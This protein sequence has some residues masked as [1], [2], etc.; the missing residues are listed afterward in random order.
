MTGG[1]GG[2]SHGFRR[3]AQTGITTR[4]LFQWRAASENDTTI[5]KLAKNDKGATINKQK[6]R[7]Q[8]AY[9]GSG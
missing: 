5:N 3:V 9:L 8:Q 2:G 7:Q 1:G 4:S 6:G